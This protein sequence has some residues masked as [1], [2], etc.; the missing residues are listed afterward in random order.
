MKVFLD[1]EGTV[2]DD[3]TNM[4]L[5]N[6]RRVGDFLQKL[7]VIEVGVF[8]FA[9]WNDND[10]NLFKTDLQSRLESVLD[11]KVTDVPTVK[12][13]MDL[14]RNSTHTHFDDASDFITMRGKKNAFMNW[15]D[16]MFPNTDCMLVDDLVPDV[17]VHNRLT[18]RSVF[19]V[20]VTNMEL[21]N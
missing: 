20:N 21:F 4:K 17:T 12:M 7:K 2:V 3:W 19:F 6:A 1:L 15:V 5:V 9:V 10:L 16:H 18:K 8:S 14:D 11:V 13:M